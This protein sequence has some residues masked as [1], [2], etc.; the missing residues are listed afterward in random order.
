MHGMGGLFS[1]LIPRNRK[2][3]Y[4]KLDDKRDVGRGHNSKLLEGE[5]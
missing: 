5:M 3:F 2:Q 1:Q 4:E